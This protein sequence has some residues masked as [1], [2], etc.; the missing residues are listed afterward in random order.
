MTYLI[1]RVWI[2]EKGQS[3]KAPNEK[4]PAEFP[5]M[6]SQYKPIKTKDLTKSPL[7]KAS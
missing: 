7:L 2:S 3:Q 4:F 5:A 6:I 1:S